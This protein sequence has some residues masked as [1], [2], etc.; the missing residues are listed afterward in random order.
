MFKRYI[1]SEDLIAEGCLY[2]NLGILYAEETV[3]NEYL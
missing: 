3:L 2:A 1:P